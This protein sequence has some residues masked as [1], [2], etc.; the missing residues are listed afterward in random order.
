MDPGNSPVSGEVAL[1]TERY[2][3][4]ARAESGGS[5]APVGAVTVSVGGTATF[6]LSPDS[7][8][9][10]GGVGAPALKDH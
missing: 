8:Y 6:T 2:E 10:V 7:G 5:I 3:V 4:T 1:T 9:E